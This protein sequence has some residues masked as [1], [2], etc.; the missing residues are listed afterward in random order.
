MVDYIENQLNLKYK[1]LKYTVLRDVW[2]IGIAYSVLPNN[3]HLTFYNIFKGESSELIKHT[4][5]KDDS[6][7]L[8][9]IIVGSKWETLAQV[10]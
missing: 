10:N 1:V 7:Y 6:K 3:F 9:K 8:N 2:K 4:T 5:P